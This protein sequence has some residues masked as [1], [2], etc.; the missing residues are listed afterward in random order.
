[1]YYIKVIDTQNNKIIIPKQQTTS[2]TIKNIIDLLKFKNINAN[3][4]KIFVNWQA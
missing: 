1:M 2:Q 4:I 3:N